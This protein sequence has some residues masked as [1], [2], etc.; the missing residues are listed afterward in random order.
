M[1]TPILAGNWK[2][3]KTYDESIDFILSIRDRLPKK[4]ILETIIL[5]PAY[6]LVS[7]VKRQG[8]N[9]RIGAQN[10]HYEELGAFTGEISATMLRSIGVKYV[11]IGHSE[12]RHYYNES[13]ADVNKKL[14]S[15]LDNNLIPI[16]CFGETEE[17]FHDQNT[18]AILSLQV[19]KAFKSI[20]VKFV[21]KVIIA[22]E[23]I[24][25]VGT[26]NTAS[27]KVANEKCKLIRNEIKKLYNEDVANK[28]RI[29]YGGS[30]S[31]SNIK[32]LISE[33][34]I[35]GCLVGGAS[36]NSDSFIE[37]ATNCLN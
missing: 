8:D 7:L 9:L 25:A 11:L 28:I 26:G 19:K 32:S 33:E 31:T 20:N 5:P 17:E 4:E 36:L 24:W 37:L 6:S 23:P 27:N 16:V 10:M 29:L 35:D 22:Y 15:A 2:M 21:D 13:D 34:N 18:D 1:R 14:L 3:H 30:V 12:R